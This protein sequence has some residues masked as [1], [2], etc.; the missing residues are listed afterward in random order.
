MEDHKFL[1]LITAH[2]PLA[3]FDALLK[4]LR[5]YE[6]IPGQIDVFIYIDYE[7]R[8]DES[9]LRELVNS[10]VSFNSLSIVV[11]SE[12]WQ[13]FSLTWA[14]KGLLREAVLNNYYDFYVYTENDMCFTSE[15]FIYWFLYKDRLKKLNLEPGFCRYETYKSKLVPFDNHKVWQLNRATS[16]VWG[17]RPYQVET[18]L[19]PLDDWFIGFAS[20]GNPYMGMMILDQEMAER[21]VHSQSFDPVRSFELT[22]FRCWPLADR[23]SMGLAFE[24]LRLG[25]EHRRVVP[26]VKVGDKVQI[27]P[28]GLIEHCDTKYSLELEDKLGRTLDISE[29]FGYA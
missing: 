16:D 3:R 18:Y 4:T 6:E 26:I 24:N 29:M 11:A 7:H 25:Q 17:D 5:G 14:H 1:V 2:N 8:E 15:N 21:Y 28:F 13:G 20:L 22:Q 19:T 12:A 9:I 10:N 23:S 27:A